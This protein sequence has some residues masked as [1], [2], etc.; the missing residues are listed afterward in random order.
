MIGVGVLGCGT[1]GP[2]HAEAVRGVF[3]S[4]LV[5][6]ADVV[7]QRAAELAARY[8]VLA[9]SSLDELLA[10][11]GVDLVLVCTPSGTHG[12]LGTR[13]AKAGRHVVLEKP[14]DVDPAAADEVIAAC[15]DAGVVCSVIS[16][17]RF[18]AG[19]VRLRSAI[20]GGELGRVVLAD[21]TA[22]WHRTQQYY[23]ADAWRGTVA[24]DGGALMNQGIHLVDLLLHLLGPATSVFCR[25][26]TLAHDMEA[27]DCCV[28]DFS[29]ASGA[30][31][32]LSV[33]TA[34]APGLAETLSVAG[35]KGTV[36][37]TAGS[38]SGWHAPSD[39]SNEVSRPS[40]ALGSRH[41]AVDAHRAQLADVVSAIET[42]RAPLVTGEDG[43]AALQAVLAAY[44]S[45]SGGE[46]VHLG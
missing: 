15:A 20:S 41:L 10:V 14:I 30:F 17:H 6:V 5:A 22:W 27:E 11:A 25:R 34:A 35:T 46:D 1:I 13:I 26:A 44:A 12:E 7:P 37:L 9:V 31:A 45:A 29:F 4:E 2:L 32:T 21:A 42:G 19:V 33:T 23:D 36:T 43:R 16:Q 18:D 38:I 8:D 40:A 3:G 28:V 24:L 39:A